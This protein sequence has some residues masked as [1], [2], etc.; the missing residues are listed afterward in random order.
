MNFTFF[1]EKM[2]Y[3]YWWYRLMLDENV[4]N[5]ALELVTGGKDV[6]T[7]SFILIFGPNDFI[8][9]LAFGYGAWKSFRG[10]TNAR[11]VN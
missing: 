6:F 4:R 10:E 2:F 3:A 11:K 5:S 1:V 9:G 8:F 7:G